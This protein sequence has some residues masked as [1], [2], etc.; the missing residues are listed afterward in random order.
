MD[1]SVVTGPLDAGP[2]VGQLGPYGQ[3]VTALDNEVVAGFSARRE[4]GSVE[5]AARPAADAG[6]DD[7]AIVRRD[8]EA[9]AIPLSDVPPEGQ[10]E[11]HVAS[12]LSARPCHTERADEECNSGQEDWNAQANQVTHDPSHEG[13][14]AAPLGMV[15]ARHATVVARRLAERHVSA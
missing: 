13:R 12:W 15:D 3:T 11:C 4:L 1:D 9:E 6:A 14:G 5:L 2:G 8:A 10:A 7:D